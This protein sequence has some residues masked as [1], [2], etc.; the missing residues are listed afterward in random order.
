MFSN[1]AGST[2]GKLQWQNGFDL[3]FMKKEISNKFIHHHPRYHWKLK[4]ASSVNFT[5]SNS[6]SILKSYFVMSQD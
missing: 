6:K 1:G 2:L 5:F 3:P 4:L